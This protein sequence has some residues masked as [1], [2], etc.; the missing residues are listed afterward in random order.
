MSSRSLP[1]EQ[2]RP[3][4]SWESRLEALKVYWSNTSNPFNLPRQWKQKHP[5]SCLYYLWFNRNV[6]NVHNLPANK[7]VLLGEEIRK[8]KSSRTR[9]HNM[10]AFACCSYIATKLQPSMYCQRTPCKTFSGK[11][12]SRCWQHQFLTPEKMKSASVYKTGRSYY[13]LVRLAA[14]KLPRHLKAGNGVYSNRHFEKNEYI[15]WY[16][17]RTCTLDE[18]KAMQGT[19]AH[20]YVLLPIRTGKRLTDKPYWVGIMTPEVGMGLGSFVNAP[21][22]GPMYQANCSFKFD[23]SIQYPVIYALRDIW[24]GEELY[25]AYGRGKRGSHA[26]VANNETDM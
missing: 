2:R 8:A 21:Y 11:N 17:G 9:A 15:T 14:S 7:R 26:L 24:P 23:A 3:R 18:V 10:K 12:A 22:A 19:L 4:A 20:D 16:A 1:Q 25:M 6:L 5:E 13:G